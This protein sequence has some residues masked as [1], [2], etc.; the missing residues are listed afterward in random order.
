MPERRVAE[1][2]ECQAPMRWVKT[3]KGKTMPID[4]DPVPDGPFVIEGDEDPPRVRFIGR[5][6][7]YTGERFNSHFETCT[8]P[9]RFSKKGKR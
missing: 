1:C 5:K 8:N 6:A 4:D 9:R 7:Q 2:R 3:Q